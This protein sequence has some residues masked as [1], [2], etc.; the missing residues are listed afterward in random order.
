MAH[1]KI[2]DVVKFTDEYGS[3]DVGRLEGWAGG[4]L[5]VMTKEGIVF[6]DPRHVMS[7]GNKSGKN[8]RKNR[9][10]KKSRKTRKNRKTRKTRK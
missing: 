5:K 9:S 6:V 4:D 2:G 7:G 10:A 8:S 3:P 1:L